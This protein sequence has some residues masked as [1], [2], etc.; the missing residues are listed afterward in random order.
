[1]LSNAGGNARISGT[2]RSGLGICL[3]P[4]LRCQH[5]LPTNMI[6][7]EELQTLVSNL[8]EHSRIRGATVQSYSL[9]R[10][11]GSKLVKTQRIQQFRTK[12]ILAC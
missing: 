11:D 2:Q 9:S 7:D 3:G 4:G 10:Q 1:M 5:Y 8:G 12:S 6:T